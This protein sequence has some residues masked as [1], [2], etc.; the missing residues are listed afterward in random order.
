MLN[1]LH[2]AITPSWQVTVEPGEPPRHPVLEVLH[3]SG[4][5][6][7]IRRRIRPDVLTKDRPDGEIPVLRFIDERGDGIDDGEN[8]LLTQYV[9]PVILPAALEL[10]RVIRVLQQSLPPK[11]DLV[12][13]AGA[14]EQIGPTGRIITA[15]IV[16]VPPSDVIIPD[17][18]GF[19]GL[20]LVFIQ[21]RT[22]T[23][24]INI[25]AQLI[26][27]EIIDPGTVSNVFLVTVDRVHEGGRRQ[28]VLKAVDIGL[29][30]RLLLQGNTVRIR[31]IILQ[32]GSL[33]VRV[34]DRGIRGGPTFAATSGGLIDLKNISTGNVR[35]GIFPR[36]QSVDVDPVSI[37]LDRL[38]QH[39]DA[40]VLT[41]QDHIDVPR[42]GGVMPHLR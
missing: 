16:R 39:V 7:R 26:A 36:M 20:V 5:G 12:T 37:T 38:H 10:I 33:T 34:V 35:S 4:I 25:L 15:A 9:L 23:V 19:Q 17:G 24:A 13:I 11:R 14:G 30:V 6:R 31:I 1:N 8:V 18:S 28:R 42:T 3:F 22:D 40:D 32:I 2:R 27:E 29:Y 21:I 41:V